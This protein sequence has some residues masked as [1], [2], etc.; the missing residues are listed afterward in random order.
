MDYV[1]WLEVK[2]FC[3]LIMFSIMVFYLFNCIFNF[4]SIPV[5]LHIYSHLDFLFLFRDPAGV[6]C[7]VVAILVL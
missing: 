2:D 4:Y 1:V 3:V 5:G 7:C 6:A